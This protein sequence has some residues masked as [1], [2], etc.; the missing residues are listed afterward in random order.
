MQ[1]GAVAMPN[2]A[3]QGTGIFQDLDQIAVEEVINGHTDMNTVLDDF[4][5]STHVGKQDKAHTELMT[6]M[7]WMLSMLGWMDQKANLLPDN[8]NT[9]P[10]PIQTEQTPSQW[11]TAVAA[12]HAEIL[13]ERACHMPL[14]TATSGLNTVSSLSS[15]V[16]NDVQVVDKSYMSC[17]FF[18]KDWQ[19][20]IDGFSRFC[21]EQGTRLHFLNHC[22]PCM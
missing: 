1:K 22:K 8:L 3:D 13:E 5:I 18:S 16:P 14:C 19:K 15:F 6:E 4:T 7:R 9:S 11:K 21:I 12:A 17:W 10:E 2:W 20:N